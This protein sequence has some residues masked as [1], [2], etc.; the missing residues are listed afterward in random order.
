MS[1]WM[2]LWVLGMW[3][4]GY[5]AGY[6]QACGKWHK[7]LGRVWARLADGIDQDMRLPTGMEVAEILK[8]ETS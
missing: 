4:L 5:S 3:M 7:K 2:L 6:A 1:G 8:Q